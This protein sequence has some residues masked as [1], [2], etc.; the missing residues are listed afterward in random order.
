M[1]RRANAHINRRIRAQ[2]CIRWMS[3]VQ[4]F[5]FVLQT[6]HGAERTVHVDAPNSAS[7]TVIRENYGENRVETQYKRYILSYPLFLRPVAVPL[8]YPPGGVPRWS[9]R[10]RPADTSARHLMTSYRQRMSDFLL[11][12]KK[13]TRAL[14]VPPR[15][16]TLRPL[17]PRSHKF[18]C[19]R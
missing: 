14:A 18:P 13:T 6:L 10:K 3:T 4:H 1:E 9:W 5:V 12:R 7:G 2:L 11:K 19:C 15:Q 8:E 16:P 17:A